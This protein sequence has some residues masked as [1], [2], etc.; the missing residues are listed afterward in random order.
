MDYISI[1]VIIGLAIG[2]LVSVLFGV[3]SKSSADAYS[4]MFLGMNSHDMVFYLIIIVLIPTFIVLTTLS[5]MIR[6]LAYPISMP[7]NFTIETL[8]MAFLPSF[9]FLLMPYLRG[10]NYTSHTMVEFL[11][12]VIKFGVLHILLQ[13]S[14]FYSSLF[15]PLLKTAGKKM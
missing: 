9:V 14:G 11:V 7:V 13:F 4:R 6:D 12:L 2:I 1:S 10:Y 3:Y 8:L 15:P 5:V